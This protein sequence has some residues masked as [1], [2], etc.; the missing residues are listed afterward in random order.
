MEEWWMKISTNNK[1]RK[2]INKK[3]QGEHWYKVLQNYQMTDFGEKWTI[4]YQIIS[5]T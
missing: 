2:Q 5:A 3:N 4:L 1:K